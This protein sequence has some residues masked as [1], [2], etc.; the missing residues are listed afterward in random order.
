[1]IFSGT[2]VIGVEVIQGSHR[3]RIMADREVILSMGAINTPKV[4]MQSGIGPEAEL[5]PHGIHVIQHLPGVGRNHQDHVSFGC[6]F[7]SKEPIAVGN[8]GSEATL[9][10]KTDPSLQVPD[11]FHCQLEFPVATPETASSRCASE[12]LDGI[13]GAV[14]SEESRFA[15]SHW[16]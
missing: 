10:W 1:M 2:T 4:L 8:G 16:R 3:T 6:I 15:A 5:R 11:V 9:Y 14:T 12:R 7:E 13:C